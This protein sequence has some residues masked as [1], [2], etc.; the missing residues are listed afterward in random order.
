MVSVCNVYFM[1][2]VVG[3][4]SKCFRRWFPFLMFIH[5]F[6][7]SHFRLF[8]VAMFNVFMVSVMARKHL[9]TVSV[10]YGFRRGFPFIY[11]L[12]F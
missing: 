1:V 2:S 10:I 3:F 12:R 9:F 6:R 11:G 4:R 5:G 8:M 7:L